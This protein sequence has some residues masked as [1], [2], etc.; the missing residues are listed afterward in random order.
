MTSF[1]V[2]LTG[3][4]SELSSS[5]FPEIVL[6]DA[7]NYSCGLLEFTSYQS[8]P[9]VTS[10]NNEITVFHWEMR[11]DVR[12]QNIY[13]LTVPVGSYEAEELLSV[14]KSMFDARNVLFEY[15]INKNTL[16]TTIKCADRV[17][18]EP[19]YDSPLSLLGFKGNYN[20]VPDRAT[21]SDGV[22]QISAVNVIRIECNIVT[23]AYVDGKLCH[24]LY[25][26]PS[27]KVG[28]GYKIIEQ[29]RNIIYLPI[30]PRRINCIQV[31]IVDQD[32]NLIDFRGETVTCRI[33]IKRD[34]R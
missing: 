5:F 2:S 4:T 16:K 19:G 1:T 3:N 31:S 23:G 15:S 27:N 9:N 14:I 6:D 21:E 32:G 17:Y 24:S 10:K 29:P 34:D 18:L 25:E 26:F 22:I 7:Y 33:H 12:H 30:I 20:I 8:I 11:D 28:V 13:V